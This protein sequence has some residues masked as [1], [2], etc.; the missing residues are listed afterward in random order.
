MRHQTVLAKM[1]GSHIDVGFVRWPYFKSGR[2]ISK[3][4]WAFVVNEHSFGPLSK[5]EPLSYETKCN[6]IK[7][8]QA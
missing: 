5:H 6:S 1:K 3:K 7:K 8:G 4:T 2:V